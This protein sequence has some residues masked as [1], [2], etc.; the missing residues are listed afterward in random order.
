MNREVSVDKR[1]RGRPEYVVGL[2]EVGR[3]KAA[4]AAR[5]SRLH[6]RH[7]LAARLSR[8]FIVGI[9]EVGRGSLAGPVAVAAV[10]VRRGFPLTTPHPR[11]KL[12]DSKKLTPLGRERWYREVRRLVAAHPGEVRYAVSR[13]GPSR[14]DRLNVA[15]AANLA[16][17]RAL[18]RL[19]TSHRLP[20]TT[21]SVFLDG[22]LFLAHPPR[23]AP[24]RLKTVIR[25]DEKIPVIKLA[26]IVAKVCRDRYM[27]KL[28]SRYPRYDF[29]VH[30]GYG[31]RRHFRALKKYGLSEVH[32]L[33]FLKKFSKV[34][35]TFA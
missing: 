7:C 28:H 4:P 29:H 30:K 1:L 15:R 31:T 17:S 25:G 5:P 24:H 23:P 6:S 12:K 32:R 8:A 14:V 21:S 35:P 33:T 20:I 27:V 26:S 11:L 10:A 18:K 13:V 19:I 34:K 22:G 2:D 16:A 3:A 9:D